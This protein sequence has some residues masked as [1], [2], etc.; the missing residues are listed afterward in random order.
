MGYFG[1]C[2]MPA[3]PAQALHQ[4]KLR[5]GGLLVHLGYFSATA[6]EAALC[7]RGL[8][9]ARS[10]GRAI[11]RRRALQRRRCLSRESSL[12]HR[13]HFRRHRLK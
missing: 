2:A 9:V 5:S 6:E 12:Q 3:R 7:L 10:P 13:T 4:V 11:K 8:C 1:A